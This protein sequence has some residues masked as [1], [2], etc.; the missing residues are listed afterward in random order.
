MPLTL[1]LQLTV[2]RHLPVP[3]VGQNQ[4][5]FVKSSKKTGS[6]LIIFKAS[7]CNH[8]WKR[9]AEM[10]SKAY[11]FAIYFRTIYSGK[12]PPQCFWNAGEAEL[13]GGILLIAMADGWSH[14][15]RIVLAC[16]YLRA[17]ID[18]VWVHKKKYIIHVYGKLHPI[19]IIRAPPALL[20]YTWHKSTKRLVEKSW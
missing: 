1:S 17:A 14:K 4:T 6:F 8:S 18:T 19:W 15:L 7:L 13:N 20:I 5:A 2:R 9:K 12:W 11:A 16:S 10:K 3:F